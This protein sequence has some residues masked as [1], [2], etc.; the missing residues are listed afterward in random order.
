MKHLLSLQKGILTMDTVF[1]KTF[2]FI[3][4]I[5]TMYMLRSSVIYILKVLTCQNIFQLLKHYRYFI[6]TF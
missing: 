4:V 6:N 1:L 3:S 5:L 2:L